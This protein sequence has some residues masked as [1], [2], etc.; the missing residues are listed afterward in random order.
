VKRINLFEPYFTKEEI[1]A[2]TDVIKSGWWK[3]GP[4][5]KKLEEE[6]CAFTKAKNA[7]SVNSATVGLD[8]I[9]KA[10]G[11]KDCEVI[12]PPI[13]FIATGVVPL[14]NNCKV[15]FADIDEQTLTI[16]A[17]DVAKKITPKT[18]AIV[19]Q[20]QSGYP[21]DLDAFERFKEKGILIIEDAAHGA[22]AFYKGEHVGT[23]NP[24]AFSFNVVKNI[25]AGEGGIVTTPDK[26]MA[27]KMKT[28]RWFGIDKIA[29]QKEGKEHIWDYSI[30]TVGYKYHFN[31]IFAVLALVQLKRLNKTNT[32]R[33][34][35]AKRYDENFSRASFPVRLLEIN[36]KDIVSSRHQYIIRVDPKHRNLL[37]HWLTAHKITSGV[38]YKPINLYPIFD[39]HGETPVTDREWEKM[40]TLPLHPRLSFSDVDY[41]CDIIASYFK[42]HSQ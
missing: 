6:F 2:V 35:L 31:D 7:V 28:L 23:R 16:D 15:V 36:S 38:H 5:C 40:V 24:S 41:I 10:Y 14:Y 25:A 19:L 22:G 4:E 37:I 1:K 39:S 21:C 11:I 26:D 18:K 33:R 30:Y 9:F 12:I 20:H 29:W 13:T 8:L 27:E 42:Q 34:A 32:K 17:A 3:E